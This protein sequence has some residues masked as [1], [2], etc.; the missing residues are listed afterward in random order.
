MVTRTTPENRMANSEPESDRAALLLIGSEMMDGAKADSNGPFAIEALAGAGVDTVLVARVP[1]QIDEIASTIRYALDRSDFVITSGGLGPTGDDLTREAASKVS[2]RPIVT[3]ETWLRKLDERL[4]K[5]GRTLDERGRRQALV[6]EGA[7]AIHNTVGLACGSHLEIDGKHLFLLPGVPAEFRAMIERS[8]IKIVESTNPA[9]KTV[10]VVKA[11]A[12]GLPEVE[13]EKT[14]APWYS[15]E[16][17][18]VS[19]LPSAGVQRISFVLTSPPIENLDSMQDEVEKSLKEGLGKNLVSLGGVELPDQIGRELL[20]KGW[21][22]AC[23]ESCTGGN[24]SKKIVSVPGASRYY[25]G[26]VTAYHND[27]KMKLLGVPVSTLEKHGAVSEETVRA[28]VRGA[29]ARFNAS[30]AVATTGIAGPTG[31][32]PGKPVGTLWIAVA[33]PVEEYATRLQFKVDRSIFTDLAS[34][35]S[36]YT[37]LRTIRRGS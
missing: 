22:L 29:R 30:C 7:D 26:G 3:D 16:G 27:A 21:T 14:L 37:L 5:R 18:R 28:M 6:L 17:I 32:V 11:L 25:M 36:L 15:K 19:I 34:N 13:A 1:D 20:E 31:E 10:R 8:V 2:C 9:K 4:A 24:I 35:Y 33:T 23:A 12:A